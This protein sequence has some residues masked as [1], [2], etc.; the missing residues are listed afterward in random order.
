MEALIAAG[1][2]HAGFEAY[3][4]ILQKEL[5]SLESSSDT[6]TVLIAD[7]FGDL[8]S[9]VGLTGVALDAYAKVVA[10]GAREIRIPALAKMLQLA[11]TTGASSATWTF[12]QLEMTLWGGTPVEPPPAGFFRPVGLGYRAEGMVCLALGC[13]YNSVRRLP[14]SG[15]WLHSGL[16]AFAP[17]ADDRLGSIPLRLTIAN[18][19]LTIGDLDQAQAEIRTAEEEIEST[20]GGD[21]YRMWLADTAIRVALHRGHLAEALRRLDEIETAARGK[22]LWGIL[23]RTLLAKAEILILLNQLEYADTCVEETLALPQSVWTAELKWERERVVRTRRLRAGLFTFLEPGLSARHMQSEAQQ[24]ALPPDN[25]PVSDPTE[26]IVWTGDT[27]RDYLLREAQV[28]EALDTAT[29]SGPAKK[30]RWTQRALT[31]AIDLEQD[32]A[33]LPSRL[34]RARIHLTA[35][36]TRQGTGGEGKTDLEQARLLFADIGA[37]QGLWFANDHLIAAEPERNGSLLDENDSLLDELTSGLA[38]DNRNSFELNKYRQR[39]WHIR[40]QIDQVLQWRSAD[41]TKG[42]GVR[43]WRRKISA[44]V[45]FLKALDQLVWELDE[46]KLARHVD[47]LQQGRRQGWFRLLSRLF[48]RSPRDLTVGYCVLPD[49]TFLYQLEWGRFDCAVLPVGRPQV[50]RLTRELH[51]TLVEGEK[52][53]RRLALRACRDVGL[54]AILGRHPG[55]C[56]NSPWSRT[57]WRRYLSAPC[58]STEKEATAHTWPNGSRCGLRKLVTKSAALL[59]AQDPGR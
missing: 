42:S 16:H 8:A 46:E 9:M 56:N 51:T 32:F 22:L 54:Q 29:R 39:E 15:A 36:I 50:Q 33:S 57:R 18:H 21:T 19:L 26:V 13:F 10:A 14:E 41:T 17:Y 52:Q 37:R 25:G 11:S 20:S 1:H 3:R 58:A 24:T 5:L 31:A 48:V 49:L 4:V 30:D 35:G 47:S 44:G 38:T 28:L 40:S 6:N 23:C 2:W 12:R 53:F 59:R 34:I 27:L 45:E 55:A 43:G 7:R